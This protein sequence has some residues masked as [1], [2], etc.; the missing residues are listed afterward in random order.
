[1]EVVD[2]FQ[3]EDDI[4]IVHNVFLNFS[5]AQVKPIVEEL[6]QFLFKELDFLVDVEAFLEVN[7]EGT[8]SLTRTL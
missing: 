5:A 3:H 2:S 7:H 1:M 6:P 8:R 4:T